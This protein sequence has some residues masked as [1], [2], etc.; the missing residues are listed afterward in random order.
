MEAPVIIEKARETGFCCGVK[1]AIAL[2]E[3][4][5]ETN[6]EVETLGPVVHNRQVVASLAERGIK[7]VSR[8]DSVKSKLVAIT[9]HGT[10][11]ATLKEIERRQ[12]K[13]IDTTCT[14]V[15]SAQKIA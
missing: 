3:K 6:G 5:A 2:L 13:A 11:P 12:L 1:R 14:I 8:L 4:A 7:Q 10:D 15:K 9:A